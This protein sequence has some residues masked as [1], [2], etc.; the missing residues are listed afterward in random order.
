MK[1]KKIVFVALLLLCALL[2]GC[3]SMQ[4]FVESVDHDNPPE[5]FSY[6][7]AIFGGKTTEFSYS[8]NEYKC[9]LD[10]FY[11]DQADFWLPHRKPEVIEDADLETR[12]NCACGQYQD[13]LSDFKA[14][15]TVL[16]KNGKEIKPY[17]TDES[18]WYLAV[19]FKKGTLP[20]KISVT[21]KATFVFDGEEK[22]FEYT[23][24]LKRRTMSLL[25]LQLLNA[26]YM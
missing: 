7:M 15:I 4:L 2:S 3:K 5:H 1:K 17:R 25:R 23:A 20:K 26:I 19:Y 21:Y 18:D 12:I 13:K 10:V 16:D 8:Y 24:A 6:P 11:P 14:T 9:N 22:S